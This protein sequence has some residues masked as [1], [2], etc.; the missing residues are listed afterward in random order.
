MAEALP[1]EESSWAFAFL[2]TPA[3]D[4]YL[5]RPIVTNLFRLAICANPIRPFALDSYPSAAS[6]SCLRARST[7]AL[8][9]LAYRIR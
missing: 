5:A 1:E 6:A 4:G 2:H 7:L 3:Q 8:A 9:A